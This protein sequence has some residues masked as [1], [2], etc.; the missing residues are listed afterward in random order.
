MEIARRQAR[1]LYLF[2]TFSGMPFSGR[3]DRHQVGEFGDTSLALVREILPEA[4]IVPGV[5]PE[6]AEGVGMERLAFVH[7]DADQYAS[8]AAA[9]RVFPPLMV[10][11]GVIVFDDYGLLPGATYAIDDWGEPIEFT[12]TSRALWRKPA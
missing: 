6:S 7:V 1:R 2:D 11:G 10:P 4:I 5:F 12:R 3:Y 9:T 8:I